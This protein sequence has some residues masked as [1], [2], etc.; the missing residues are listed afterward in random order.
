[1]NVNALLVTGTCEENWDAHKSDCSGFVKAVAADLKDTTF[2]PGDDANRIV[3]KLE[4]APNWIPIPRGNGV[5]AK[6]QAD[7]GF[8]VIGGL[9]GS[10]MVS[11]E[12]HGHVVVVVTGPLDP[13][14]DKYPTAYWGHLGGVGAKAQTINW[15]WLAA[16]R[17][18]VNYFAKA[19]SAAAPP[20]GPEGLPNDKP[21]V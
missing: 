2:V 19:L 9:K 3:G 10:D 4:N 21:A 8:F 12:E 7:A 18:N 14:H 17:D 20:A 5:V 11:P 16:D 1:M 13:T 15:A 6:A